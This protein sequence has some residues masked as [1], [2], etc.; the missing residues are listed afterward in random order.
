MTPTAQAQAGA[1]TTTPTAQAQVEDGFV[2]PEAVEH[3][4]NLAVEKDRATDR[5]RKEKSEKE[6]AEKV[7]K[8]ESE[9]GIMVGTLRPSTIPLN[10]FRT[11]A[12]KGSPIPRFVRG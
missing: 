8:V 7:K 1:E 6:K 2:T 5:E 10:C 12:L 4:T 11:D 3:E 9:G